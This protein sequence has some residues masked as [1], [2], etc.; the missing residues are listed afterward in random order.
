MSEKSSQYG[1]SA[2]VTGHFSEWSVPFFL[3]TVYS[4]VVDG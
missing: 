1:I 4:G 3:H 2:S